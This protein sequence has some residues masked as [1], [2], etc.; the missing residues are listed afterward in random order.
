ME[1]VGKF[2]TFRAVSVTKDA[3]DWALSLRCDDHPDME[4]KALMGEYIKAMAYLD[5]TVQGKVQYASSSNGV[6]RFLRIDPSSLTLVKE[7][8][9]DEKLDHNGDP[10]TE[11]EFL[12]R[13]STGCSWCSDVIPYNSEWVAVS[14]GQC[15]CESCTDLSD[16]KHFLNLKVA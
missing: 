16:V 6:F 5:Q 15:V 1:L 8:N 14:S 11:E 10:I 2:L 3:N 9:K 13:Y 4:F 12:K 7:Q